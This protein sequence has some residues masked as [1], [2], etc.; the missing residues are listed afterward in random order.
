M[1]FPFQLIVVLQLIFSTTCPAQSGDGQ[2]KGQEDPGHYLLD[3]SYTD[4]SS[5]EGTIDVFSLG[6]TWL[7]RPD[8]RVGATTTYVTF[9]PN[10]VDMSGHEP[11]VG[12]IPRFQIGAE[13]F[14]EFNRN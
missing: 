12:L 13:Y 1:R 3:L 10:I 11:R 7:V 4:T 8:L 5:F 9:N 14:N 6:F 2:D